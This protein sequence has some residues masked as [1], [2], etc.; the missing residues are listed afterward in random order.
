LLKKTLPLVLAL[1]VGLAAGAVA[2]DYGLFEQAQQI[3]DLLSRA[4][5]PPQAAPGPAPA[6]PDMKDL[7]RDLLGS[8]DI[9]TMI[10]SLMKDPAIDLK[11]ISES[12]AR[13]VSE[14]PEF[15][16]AMYQQLQQVDARKALVDASRSPEFR[17]ALREI[18][19]S[20]EFRKIYRDITIEVL[21]TQKLP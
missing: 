9:Q 10:Q 14:S 16:K 18:L 1:L 3:P 17:Q 6:Q 7:I 2:Q 13:Y 8:K 5:Q 20:S 15:R 4:V 12:V 19:L 21:K 11:A